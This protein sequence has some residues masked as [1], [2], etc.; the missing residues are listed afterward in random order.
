MAPEKLELTVDSTIVL[1]PFL[2]TDKKTCPLRAA[3]HASTA[4]PTLPS[5]EFLKPVG[6]G[7]AEVSSL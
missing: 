1:K 2:P 3:R 5:V 6:I 4:T 7:R